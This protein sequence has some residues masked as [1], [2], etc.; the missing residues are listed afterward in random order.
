MFRLQGEIYFLYPLLEQF[1]H[2]FT[3]NFLVPGLIMSGKPINMVKATGDGKP[4][5]ITH[6]K[7]SLNSFVNAFYGRQ[8]ME[9]FYPCTEKLW[10][11]HFPSKES[12]LM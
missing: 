12:E 11:L 7:H 5:H 2:W 1:K 6:F 10:L 8:A 3:S 4:F 9:N